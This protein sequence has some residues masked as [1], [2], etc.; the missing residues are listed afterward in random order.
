VTS[1]KY[2]LC[3]D[4]FSSLEIIGKLRHSDP[5]VPCRYVR[6]REARSAPFHNFRFSQQ[7]LADLQ[8]RVAASVD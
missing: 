1:Q 8:C 6:L 7:S 5:R 3:Q 4:I 2:L